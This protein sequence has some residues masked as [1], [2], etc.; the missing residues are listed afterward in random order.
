[1]SSKPLNMSL[2]PFEALCDLL[3]TAEEYQDLL[4]YMKEQPFIDYVRLDKLPGSHL[5][6]EI[7]FRIYPDMEISHAVGI[8]SLLTD[9]YSYSVLH[10][11]KPSTIRVPRTQTHWDAVKTPIDVPDQDG[12][13]FAKLVT[14]YA[15]GQLW[16]GTKLLGENLHSANAFLSMASRLSFDGDA[17]GENFTRELQ[18]NTIYTSLLPLHRL[19]LWQIRELHCLTENEYVPLPDDL[20]KRIDIEVMLREIPH[21][22]TKGANKGKIAYTENAKKGAADVQSV[23]KPGKYLRRALKDAVTDQQLKDLV[24]ELYSSC[25][26]EVKTT[27]DASE[28]ARVYME[29]PNS[30]MSHGEDRFDRTIDLNGNWRHP[31]EAYEHPDSAIELVWIEAQGRPAARVLVNTANML[32]STLYKSDW[33][34]A[35]Q[36][37]LIDWLETNGYSYSSEAL[38]GQPLAVIELENGGILCPYIDA[39][40]RPVNIDGD[41]LIIGDG[42]F[43]VD[44]DKGFFYADER[45][46]EDDEEGHCDYGNHDCPEDELAIVEGHGHVCDDCRREHFVEAFVNG[47]N[48]TELMHEHDA[49][50]LGIQADSPTDAA[51]YVADDFEEWHRLDVVPL[52]DGDYAMR[53]DAMELAG[54]DGDE[55]DEWVERANVWTDPSEP[56]G[57][58]RHPDYVEIDGYA[59]D[60][61]Y[62]WFDATNRCWNL[63]STLDPDEDGTLTPVDRFTYRERDSADDV[64]D[65]CA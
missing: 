20:A 50:Y 23:M 15:T 4:T 22:G 12:T 13:A 6:F 49:I 24:A 16:F 1:M 34:R 63:R 52:H 32:R 35:A 19:S 5:T 46:A 62:A 54:E 41:R 57:V 45:D 29:G 9:L 8:R 59:I 36:V 56:P 33:C 58:G 48:H 38:D 65:E 51:D 55:L 60:I 31:V 18:R 53:S 3:P 14:C 17:S 64:M 47:S 42:D 40:G 25:N 26:L 10:E 11:H 30:C 2:T 61:D 44:H 39:S 21:L 27:T 43:R 28:I 37:T 7:R